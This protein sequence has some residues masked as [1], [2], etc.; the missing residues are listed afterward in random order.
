MTIYA[1]TLCG[2]V[3]V[4]PLM[5]NSEWTDVRK[6]KIPL[7]IMSS[8]LPGH[9]VEKHG[10]R[11]FRHNPGAAPEAAVRES[12]ED[13][14][15]LSEIVLAA[16]DLGWTVRSGNELPGVQVDVL[17]QAPSGG[18]RVAFSSAVKTHASI[19]ETIVADA[20]RITDAVPVL[21][22]SAGSE[23]PKALHPFA[24]HCVTEAEG[25]LFVKG[26]PLREFVQEILVDALVGASST[27]GHEAEEEDGV[28]ARVRTLNYFGAVEALAPMRIG[29][30]SGTDMRAFCVRAGE[31]IDWSP[32]PKAARDTRM[33][34]LSLVNVGLYTL[35]IRLTQTPTTCWVRP[36]AG[37]EFSVGR[38]LSP[39]RDPQQ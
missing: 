36:I 33:E 23:L 7:T 34:T 26:T 32:S 18:H 37:V 6:N 22:V 14:R 11:F 9:S 28:A 4:A 16:D 15:V 13:L 17:C 2:K 38:R 29:K 8:K 3:L 39:A 27:N 21:F 31:P 20:A 5:S 30:P 24:V 10:I 12:F 19:G 35:P 25:D 1:T